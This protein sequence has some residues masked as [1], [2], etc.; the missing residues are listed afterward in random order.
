VSVRVLSS[1]CLVVL[2]HCNARV[3]RIQN[4]LGVGL[5]LT[6]RLR[7]L[8]PCLKAGSEL[9]DWSVHAL[10]DEVIEAQE[11]TSE[12]TVTFHDYPYTRPNTS[13][14]QFCVSRNT[15]EWISSWI[16]ED[17]PRGRICDAIGT[18]AVAFTSLATKEASRPAVIWTRGSQ[19]PCS[20]EK[21]QIA[22]ILYIYYIY[23]IK[24]RFSRGRQ[25]QDSES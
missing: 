13:V 10:T 18:I 5:I 4:N 7:L 22:A 16:I 8:A 25:S 1:F 17:Q 11:G 24:T 20:H 19:A 21:D 2:S 14:D 15:S 12:L 3:L 9:F 23:T 6:T